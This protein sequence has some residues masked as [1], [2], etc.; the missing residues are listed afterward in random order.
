[1]TFYIVL[2]V[3]ASNDLIA[4]WLKISV[5]TTTTVFQVLLIVLP[6]IVGYFVYRLM[7]ALQLSGV[8]RFSEM[9]ARALRSHRS[10]AARDRAR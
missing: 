9:P 6:P 10:G 2:F 4:K 8:E 3:A 7:K 5:L 1:M